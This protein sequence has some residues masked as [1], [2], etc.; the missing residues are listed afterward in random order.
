MQKQV[1]AYSGNRLLTEMLRPFFVK[2]TID[3][4]EQKDFF[5]LSA[6]GVTMFYDVKIFSRKKST[7]KYFAVKK[8]LTD[9]VIEDMER[10]FW[11]IESEI[12]KTQT[13]LETLT[14]FWY[15]VSGPTNHTQKKTGK[16]H[17][18]NKCHVTWDSDWRNI[19]RDL[20]KI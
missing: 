17:C 8:K 11:K 1:T 18:K 10:L 5:H 13:K 16:R 2:S 19:T 3:F 4:H 9:A 15:Q 14:N 6:F 7:E 20:K 12:K